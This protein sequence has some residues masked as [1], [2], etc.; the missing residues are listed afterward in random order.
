MSFHP[1]IIAFHGLMIDSNIDVKKFFLF[2]RLF[3][4][5]FG[6]RFR[7][8]APDGLGREYCGG[9]ADVTDADAYEFVDSDNGAVTGL[10]YEGEGDRGRTFS[11]VDP[12]RGRNPNMRLGETEWAA[13]EGSVV[14]WKNKFSILKLFVCLAFWFDLMLAPRTSQI[15]WRLG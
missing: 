1:L 12:V 6:F 10:A 13:T 11:G 9:A 4:C 7:L 2:F 5:C 15:G 3:C 14:A 8:G